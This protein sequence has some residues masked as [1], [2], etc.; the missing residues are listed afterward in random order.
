MQKNGVRWGAWLEKKGRIRFRFAPKRIAK[1][2]ERIVFLDS[3]ISSNSHTFT[4]VKG[5]LIEDIS[6]NA[7]CDALLALDQFNSQPIKIVVSSNGGDT[8]AGMQV[9]D[10]ILALRSPVWMI[11]RKSMSMATF[12]VAIGAKGHRY[13][14]KNATVH[15]HG[16]FVQIEGKMADVMMTLEHF[17]SLENRMLD[18]LI[19]HTRLSEVAE[20]RKLVQMKLLDI[21]NPSQEQQHNALREALR[22]WLR[23]ERFFTPEEAIRYGIVDQII[24]PEIQQELFAIRNQSKQE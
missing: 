18:L 20:V 23:A 21:A 9:I 12:I 7:I 1:G 13:V 3:N 14:Q 5:I 24:T 6:A 4:R 2:S 11:V 8:L 10:T 16:A 19:N 15:L 17:T 22:E